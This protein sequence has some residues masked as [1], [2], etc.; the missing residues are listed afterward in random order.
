MR[1][2][3]IIRLAQQGRGRK[4]PEGGED[5]EVKKKKESQSLN[6]I[7]TLMLQTYKRKVSLNQ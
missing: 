2:E 4:M 1:S 5:R 6:C 7:T 3:V